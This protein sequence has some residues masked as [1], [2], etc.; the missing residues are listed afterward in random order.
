MRANLYQSP[1]CVKAPEFGGWGAVGRR[2]TRPWKCKRSYANLLGL[3][4]GVVS[5][6]VLA[7]EDS[8]ILSRLLLTPIILFCYVLRAVGLRRAGWAGEKLGLLLLSVGFRKEIVSAN[9]RLALAKELSERELEELRERVYRSIGRTFLEIARNFALT[10]RQMRDELFVSEEDRLYLM[11]VL[12]RGKG[13]V[14]VSGHIANWELLAMGMA[15]RGFPVAIVVK[16]MNSALSQALIER[17]RRRTGL[18][19]IYAGG[20]IEKMKAVL[21]RGR[22]IGFMVDQNIT[23]TKGIRANFFGVPAASIRG[24]AGLVKET[25]VPVIPICAYRQPDGTHR[26]RVFPELPY[27]VAEELLEGSEERLLR[28]EWLNTQQY[29]TAVENLVRAHPE[30]WLWIHRRWKAS[31]E[32]LSFETAHLENRP[33]RK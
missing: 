27:L 10:G 15:A 31:R 20:T 19:V 3:E 14:F 22:F 5:A 6:A 1:G 28:E 7:V 2:S 13:A 33:G 17:Q 29:Q 23:G 25:G 16:R 32:P 24:L 4:R 18:E 21:G 26:V 11:E 8:I 30:Q 9:L 12:Q